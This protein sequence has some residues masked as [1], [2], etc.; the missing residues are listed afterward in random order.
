MRQRR[1]ATAS[2]GASRRADPKK[3]RRSYKTKYMEVMDMIVNIPE[4]W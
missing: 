1:P 2:D 3:R 4:V